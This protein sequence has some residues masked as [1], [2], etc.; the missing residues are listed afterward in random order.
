ML[1]KF[2]ESIMARVSP[3]NPEGVAAYRSTIPQ[4]INVSIEHHSDVLVATIN[5]ID[6]KKINGLL[7]TEAKTFDQ[8]VENV[9]DLLFTYIN[10]PNRIRPFYSRIFTPSDKTSKQSGRLTLVKA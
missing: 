1:S 8:V 6:G 4:E 3:V 2:L 5:S 7:I 10:M 9:N